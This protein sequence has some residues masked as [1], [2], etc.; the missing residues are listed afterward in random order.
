MYHK[1][2]TPYHDLGASASVFLPDHTYMDVLVK[3]VINQ[4]PSLCDTLGK[5]VVEYEAVG[6]HG[7]MSRLQ[8]IVEIGQF[9][10]SL[11]FA[12]V[13]S[14]AYFRFHDRNRHPPSLT[15]SLPSTP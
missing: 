12:S 13:T 10:L 2:D 3:T 14:E 15:Q 11:M 7:F 6:P 5:Y 4:V 9:A 1:L 8:R